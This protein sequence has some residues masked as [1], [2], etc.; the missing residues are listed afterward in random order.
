MT[1]A[2]AESA[3]SSYERMPRTYERRRDGT[4]DQGA[5]RAERS[6]GAERAERAEGDGLQEKK[7]VQ[8]LHG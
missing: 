8:V 3:I 2:T 5:E 6:E 1:R 4:E 7:E